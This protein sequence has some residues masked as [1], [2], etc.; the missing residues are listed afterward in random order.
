MTTSAKAY[1]QSYIAGLVIMAALCALACSCASPYAT[2]QKFDD[3]LAQKAGIPAP[4]VKQ[5]RNW[6]GI[7]IAGVATVP[8]GY[9]IGWDA[10]LDGKLIDESRITRV[11]RLYR[12]DGKPSMVP[13]PTVTPADTTQTTAQIMSDIQH[14]ISNAASSSALLEAIGNAGK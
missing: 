10:W 11:P 1:I 6:L 7:P 8:E 5:A 2:V 13:A 12:L 3:G 9:G 14:S 4:V